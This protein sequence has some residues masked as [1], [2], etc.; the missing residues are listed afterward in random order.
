[1]PAHAE[2]LKIRNI[3]R[4][5]MKCFISEIKPTFTISQGLVTFG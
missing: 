3:A 2:P 1:V 5:R 4:T